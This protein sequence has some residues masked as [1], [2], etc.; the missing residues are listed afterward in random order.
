MKKIETAYK[1]SIH[2]Q[3]PRMTSKQQALINDIVSYMEVLRN[4]YGITPEFIWNNINPTHRIYVN[5]DSVERCE[6]W[7]HIEPEHISGASINKG[8]QI[9]FIDESCSSCNS[10]NDEEEKAKD[11][12]FNQVYE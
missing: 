11:I 7:E 5:D 9:T 1:Y 10:C 12:Q 4:I 3:I 6:D 2:T 8:K